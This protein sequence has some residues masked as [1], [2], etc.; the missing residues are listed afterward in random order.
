MHHLSRLSLRNLKQRM[1]AYIVLKSQVCCVC[2][3]SGTFV[4]LP[5][6]LVAFVACFSLL[7]CNKQKSKGGLEEFLLEDVF[8]AVGSNSCLMVA[9]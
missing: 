3:A 5:N 4:C 2:R 1:S 6:N 9:L 8:Y 7:L